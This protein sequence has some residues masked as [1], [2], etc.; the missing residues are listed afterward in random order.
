[1]KNKFSFYIDVFFVGFIAFILSL[2]LFNFFTPHPFS[3]IFSVLISLL[4]LILFFFNSSK[5]QKSA[6]LKREQVKEMNLLIS[7]LNFST[8]E[9]QC[10]IIETA[11]KN[12]RIEREKRKNTLILKAQ[13]AL[14]LCRFSFNAITKADIVRAYNLLTTNQKV[15][16]LSEKFDEQ[17]QAFANRFGGRVI[18]LDGEKVY[19]FIK[20]NH[21]MP[22]EFKYKN[23]VERK[24]KANFKNLLDKKKAKSF[25]VFGTLF[26]AFSYISPLKGYYITCGCLFLIYSLV[27]RLMGKD[28]KLESPQTDN[29]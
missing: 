28:L 3:I 14:V 9:E 5:K 20:D 4:A 1:M 15:Y 18:L 10:E 13:N 11:L 16:I 27:L 17:V 23:F 26:L 12:A 25:F 8:K 2:V 21:A 6:R 19:K 24:S 7:E 29:I 22:K